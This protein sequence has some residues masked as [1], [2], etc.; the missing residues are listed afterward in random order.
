MIKVVRLATWKAEIRRLKV[1]GQTARAKR[2]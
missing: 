1:Q 2:E